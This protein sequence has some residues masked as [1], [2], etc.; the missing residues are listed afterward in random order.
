MC[1]TLLY[2][3]N[4]YFF[5]CIMFLRFF[6]CI[7]LLCFF[8]FLIVLYRCK[9]RAFVPREVTEFPAVHDASVAAVPTVAKII[10]NI[11]SRY[12][13]S[14][15]TPKQFIP[16]R[17]TSRSKAV[18]KQ[19]MWSPASTLCLVLCNSTFRSWHCRIRASSSIREIRSIYFSRGTI[20]LFC[21]CR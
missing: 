18:A 11:L 17:R 4:V 8:I 16:R 19:S 13:L 1:F 10:A 20:N 9:C 21:H 6:I 2:M 3:H 15:V 7:M 14:L 5:M 12:F